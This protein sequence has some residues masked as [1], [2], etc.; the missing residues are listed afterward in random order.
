M[1]LKKRIKYNL[2]RYAYKYIDYKLYKQ[3][4]EEADYMA[5]LLIS[6]FPLKY[7]VVKTDKKLITYEEYIKQSL[8]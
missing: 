2:E 4:G 3:Y 1:K 7:S 5:V 6:I 8:N